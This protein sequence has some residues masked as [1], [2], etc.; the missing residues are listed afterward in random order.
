[1]KA[2]T[3]GRPRWTA[4]VTSLPCWSRSEKAGT[5]AP[6]GRTAPLNP[7][8]GAALEASE[9]FSAADQTPASTA[10]A[11][12]KTPIRTRRTR[13]GTGHSVG[14]PAASRLDQPAADRVA[15]ELDA[16]AHAELAQDVRA[17]RLD[18]LLGQ[19]Q[20]LRDGLVRVG[21]RDQLEHLLLARGQR[22]LRAG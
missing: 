1:M 21:L 9:D 22:L 10:K 13:C 16:V 4:G 14:T 15:D 3:A 8:R 18:G 19:V 5:R 2:Y 12:A 11:Q 6:G 7:A 20:R 17:V